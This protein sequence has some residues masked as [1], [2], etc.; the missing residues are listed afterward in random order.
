MRFSSK[1]RV[2]STEDFNNIRL[3]G[4][5][6]HT[7]A[8]ILQGVK[9]SHDVSR[10]GIIASR[11]VGNAVKRN[12]AKRLF[13]EI[14]RNNYDKIPPCTDLVIVVRSQFANYS[15]SDLQTMFTQACDK[16]NS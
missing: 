10:I 11:K 16:L 9:S 3:K 4:K 2:R 7:A 15:F 1:H 12:R 6:S 14:F 13:R 5:R 8:F